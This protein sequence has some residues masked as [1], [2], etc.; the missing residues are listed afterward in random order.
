MGCMYVTGAG[1]FYSKYLPFLL[2]QGKWRLLTLRGN[3]K[4]CLEKQVAFAR[5]PNKSIEEI[6]LAEMTVTL[7]YKN[8][9]KSGHFMGIVILSAMSWSAHQMSGADYDGD[10]AFIIDKDTVAYFADFPKKIFCFG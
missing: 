8:A 9:L 6:L 3:A 10:F 5:T 2:Q 7:A 4:K 1:V